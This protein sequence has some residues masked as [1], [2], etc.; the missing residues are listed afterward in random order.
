[1]HRD[2]LL[3]Q[4]VDAALE[5]HQTHIGV[6]KMR[7][8]DD[9][10]VQFYFLKHLFIIGKLRSVGDYRSIIGL[11]IVGLVDRRRVS[12]FSRVNLVG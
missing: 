11:A 7:R 12:G 3:D 1:M 10:G 8:R 2:R 9:H 5:S 6:I 4:H